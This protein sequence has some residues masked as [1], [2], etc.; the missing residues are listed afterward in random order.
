MYAHTT[1]LVVSTDRRLF[2]IIMRQPPRPG[3]RRKPPVEEMPSALS[4]EVISLIQRGGRTTK[5]RIVEGMVF[6]SLAPLFD[7]DVLPA[8][9]SQ[10]NPST[11]A[12]NALERPSTPTDDA[13]EE[14]SPEAPSHSVS[15][16]FF[17]L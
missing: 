17:H 8:S 2:H 7:D 15:V 12:D 16:S 11:L 4:V 9:G 10:S 5:K 3:K 6:D 14:P 13:S 1:S